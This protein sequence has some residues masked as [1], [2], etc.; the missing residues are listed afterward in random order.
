MIV[1]VIFLL[2]ILSI[3]W[4]V[5]EPISGIIGSKFIGFIIGLIV[6]FK[7]LCWGLAFLGL[8]GGLA[9]I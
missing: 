2:I 5:S 8:G 9:R 4:I 1:A 7:F 3:A 6:A